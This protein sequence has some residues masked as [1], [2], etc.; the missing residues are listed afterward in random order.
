MELTV[1]EEVKKELIAH[2]WDPK[3]I[4]CNPKRN[5][6]KPTVS[7]GRGTLKQIRSSNEEV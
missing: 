7:I 2:G 3:L 4:V 1:T 5:R 6:L